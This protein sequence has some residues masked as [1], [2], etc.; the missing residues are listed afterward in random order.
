MAEP[1]V[2]RIMPTYKDAKSLAKFIDERGKIQSREK[3]GLTAKEQRV[4]TREIKR[5][6]HLGLLP[7]TQTV[8]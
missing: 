8:R 7:F 1:K 4:I 5:S 3:L 6:R 2:A